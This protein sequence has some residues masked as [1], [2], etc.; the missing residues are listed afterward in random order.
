MLQACRCPACDPAWRLL[1]W[2]AVKSYPVT[3]S[4]WLHRIQIQLLNWWISLMWDLLMTSA[5]PI[6]S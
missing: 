6:H 2:Q 5:P 4:R 1:P 3:S